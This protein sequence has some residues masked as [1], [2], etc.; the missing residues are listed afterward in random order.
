LESDYD[1]QLADLKKAERHYR[2]NNSKADAELIKQRLA[3]N[4]LFQG[5]LRV[6]KLDYAAAREP[7]GNALVMF[8]D[9]QH[10]KLPAKE[11]HKLMRYEADTHHELGRAH[12]GLGMA[13]TRGSVKLF[14]DAE[15]QF[16]SG[17][18]LRHRL[19]DEV[20][21]QDGDEQFIERDLARSYG[22][23]GD[24]HL[25]VGQLDKAIAEYDSSLKFRTELYEINRM[26]PE[27]RFQYARG[28]ANFAEVEM[29]QRRHLLQTIQ[30]VE[31]ATKVQEDLF[32][33]FPTIPEFRSDL[34]WTLLQLAE[35]ELAAA[36][37]PEEGEMLTKEQRIE[38]A[39]S[40]AEKAKL[41]VLSGSGS[42]AADPLT[43]RLKAYA[44][45]LIAESLLESDPK[46]A[47]TR[48]E[49]AKTQMKGLEDLQHEEYFKLAVIDAILGQ[50][51]DAM[52]NL[53]LAVETGSKQVERFQIHSK[54]GLKK[55]LE[56]PPDRETFDGLIK[57]MGGNP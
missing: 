36:M 35:L 4:Q 40:S 55:V 30:R 46:G 3:F 20:V 14:K 48:A 13:S 15:R 23:L 32:K 50:K 25:Q 51:S 16:A 18:E 17:L 45:L 9:L 28:L 49:E 43:I 38:K 22:F 8:K 27:I 26:E 41:K 5:Q 57:Q 39:R 19:Q 52:F 56:S 24:L 47:V 10:S 31:Q 21:R 42:N 34:A 44:N 29:V 37:N 6:R 54:L 33:D 12:L 1:T 11:T 7:L 53:K 2:E